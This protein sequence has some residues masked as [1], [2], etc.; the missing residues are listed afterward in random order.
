MVALLVGCTDERTPEERITAAKHNAIEDAAENG[1]AYAKGTVAVQSTPGLADCI[2][3]KVEI[4]YSNVNVIRC[5]LSSTTTSYQNGKQTVGVHTIE[6]DAAANAANA[7]RGA[8]RAAVAQQI[9][10]LQAKQK[11]LE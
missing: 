2:Y 5:P 6:T 4:N 10:D 3:R 8:E 11:A 1:E 7:A 9:A